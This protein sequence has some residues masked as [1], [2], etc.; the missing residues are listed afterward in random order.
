MSENDLC[1]YISSLD[2]ETA[3][4]TESRSFVIDREDESYMCYVS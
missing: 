1:G 2:E 4:P 3:S